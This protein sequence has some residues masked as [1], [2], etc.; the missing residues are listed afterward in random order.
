MLVEQTQTPHREGF[1]VD[2][3]G[4]IQSHLLRVLP[5]AKFC[6]NTLVMGICD[7]NWLHVFS[8]ICIQISQWVFRTTLEVF[9]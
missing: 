2:D 4:F 5:G 3:A 7:E 9:V 8:F 6:N 1:S